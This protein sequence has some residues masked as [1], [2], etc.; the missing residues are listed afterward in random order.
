WAEA[1]PFRETRGY[2]QGIV[3]NTLQYQ[4]LYDEGGRFRENVGA[5]RQARPATAPPA[6]SQ[7]TSTPDN[8][9]RPRRVTPEKDEEK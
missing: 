9:L 4:R 5:S 6:N 7:T 8:R 1:V 2:V 3:R